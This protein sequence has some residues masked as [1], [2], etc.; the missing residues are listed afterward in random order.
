MNEKTFNLYMSVSSD[1][2]S[3]CEA[4]AKGDRNIGTIMSRISGITAQ[5]GVNTY[6]TAKQIIAMHR[7]SAKAEADPV[8]AA[9]AD[10]IKA[11]ME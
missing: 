4:N 5:V 1:M 9:L 10:Q 7:A 3:L 6:D 2:S 11:S 8:T